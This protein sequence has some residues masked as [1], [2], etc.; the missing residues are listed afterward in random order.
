MYWVHGEHGNTVTFLPGREEVVTLH[1]GR[2]CRVTIQ[3][4]MILMMIMMVII[5]MMM[6]MMVYTTSPDRLKPN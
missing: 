5:M 6:I 4:V 3:V 2:E 1:D